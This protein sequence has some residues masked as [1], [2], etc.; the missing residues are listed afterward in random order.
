MFLK[1]P[2]LIFLC[3]QYDIQSQFDCG[4]V[5]INTVGFS[6][7]LSFGAEDWLGS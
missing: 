6:F 1:Y 5:T 2:I 7:R 3:S 4:V